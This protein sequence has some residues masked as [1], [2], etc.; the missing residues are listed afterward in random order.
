MAERRRPSIWQE[1]RMGAEL[2]RMLAHPIY[3]GQGVP[4]GDKRVV[5]VLPGL[6]AND[7]YLEPLH[8]WLR[9]I[10]YTPLRST[11]LVNAGCPQELC[12]QV[13]SHLHAQMKLRSGPVAIL[14]HSRGGILAWAMAARLG[15]KLSDLILLGSPAPAVARSMS[16]VSLQNAPAGEAVARASARARRILDPDCDVPLCGCPFPTDLQ[17][18]VSAR[19]K[20]LS[21]YSAEDP[22]VP[23][24]ACRV[25]HA[26]NIEVHGTHSGLPYN[27]DA[28]RAIADALADR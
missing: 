9:R 11:L 10:G 19:T 18:H 4:R 12:E 5:L 3:T 2:A 17:K 22:I 15:D 21:I 24:S 1:A 25:P 14:G 23:K 8:R 16:G 20:V 27:V 6:F 13:E 28:L 7:L 26:T